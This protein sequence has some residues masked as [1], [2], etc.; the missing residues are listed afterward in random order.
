MQPII[1]SLPFLAFPTDKVLAEFRPVRALMVETPAPEGAIRWDRYYS[2]D[3]LLS[4]DLHDPRPMLEAIAQEMGYDTAKVAAGEGETGVAGHSWVTYCDERWLPLLVRW[5]AGDAQLLVTMVETAERGNGMGT[6]LRMT[7]LGDRAALPIMRRLTVALSRF[8][9]TKQGHCHGRTMVDGVFR[10][11]EVPEIAMNRRPTALRIYGDKH[12][13][14]SEIRAAELPDVMLSCDCSGVRDE[15]NTQPDGFAELYLKQRHGVDMKIPADRAISL[16]MVEM[17][18]KLSVQAARKLTTKDLGR[19]FASEEAR[20][21]LSAM[22][23]AVRDPEASQQ[24][25]AYLSGALLEIARVPYSEDGALSH[26]GLA[27]ETMTL[28]LGVT[29]IGDDMRRPISDVFIG[30]E[31][32]STPKGMSRGLIELALACVDC[33]VHM[34]RDMDPK[35][36][37]NPPKAGWTPPLMKEFFL[38]G[39]GSPR[40]RILKAEKPSFGIHQGLPIAVNY[41][42]V[43]WRKGEEQ[44]MAI[45]F[46]YHQPTDGVHLARVSRKRS[47][48]E[49]QGLTSRDRDRGQS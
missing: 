41:S 34:M 29:S 20:N 21:K 3:D 32:K 38:D 18:Q 45:D 49:G 16:E 11:V 23:L 28:R 6:D 22:F 30:A 7:I 25:R 31:P 26:P 43:V 5:Q 14:L 48:R 33:G 12:G 39:P 8:G 40:A 15:W 1:P 35:E 36:L 4:L 37:A 42:A 27:F 47:F 17:I 19:N 2:I 44:A 24:Q 10:K 9:L 46:A 13:A